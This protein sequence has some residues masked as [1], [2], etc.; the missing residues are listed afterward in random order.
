MDNTI[1]SKVAA[2]ILAEPI[3]LKVGDN[4]L[5]IPRPTLG[6]IIEVSRMVSSFTECKFSLNPND[7]PIEALR[8]AREFKGIE[9][10]VAMLVLGR[11]EALKGGITLFGHTIR[12]PRYKR[13]GRWILDH[14]TPQGMAN[15]LIA[16]MA[17]MDSAFF[18]ATITSLN[19]MNNL[20]PTK[21]TA[22]TQ[23]GQ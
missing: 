1:E 11:K 19:K 5:T 15:I 21:E 18:L 4:D 2:S 17:G 14:I 8:I 13:Y 10:V 20:K 16:V 23:S 6:T 7:M 3:K 9:D 12:E 22:Q